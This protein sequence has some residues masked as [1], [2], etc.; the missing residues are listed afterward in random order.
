[1]NLTS[2]FQMLSMGLSIFGAAKQAFDSGSSQLAL[3]APTD[4]T[5]EQQFVAQYY[6]SNSLATAEQGHYAWAHLKESQGWRRGD[7]YDAE[8]K[9]HPSLVVWDE[10]PNHLQL[11]NSVTQQII[12]MLPV[13][14]ATKSTIGTVAGA[15]QEVQNSVA[16]LIGAADGGGN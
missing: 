15:A 6:V 1:M 4:L 7:V 13:N 8:K 3:P 11:K 5:E 9:L 16:P 14:D 2:I 12:S 10:L